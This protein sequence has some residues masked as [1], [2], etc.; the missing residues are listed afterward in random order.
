M[1]TAAGQRVIYNSP[2]VPSS[3]T[4]LGGVA[5]VKDVFD[6]IARIVYLPSQHIRHTRVAASP[7]TVPNP[8][9]SDLGQVI[10]THKAKVDFATPAV[11]HAAFASTGCR[12]TI[13]GRASGSPPQEEGRRRARTTTLRPQAVTLCATAVEVTASWK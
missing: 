4:T 11:D 3:L 7:L 13:T 8:E 9:G 6:E 10:Y 12:Q 2:T 1:A 5:H